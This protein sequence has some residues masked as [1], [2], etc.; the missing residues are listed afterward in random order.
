[1]T[2]AWKAHRLCQAH[3]Q[4]PSQ[5]PRLP[6]APTSLRPAPL[7]P[8]PRWVRGA[9][10]STPQLLPT[11]V[12]PSTSAV[13]QL[14]AGGWLLPD[15]SPRPAGPSLPKEAAAS[16]A[17]RKHFLSRRLTSWSVKQLT[18]KTCVPPKGNSGAQSRA[19]GLSWTLAQCQP[20]LL[21]VRFWAVSS[22]FPSACLI[23]VL[24]LIYKSFSGCHALFF[25]CDTFLRGCHRAGS[26]CSQLI[27]LSSWSF[28]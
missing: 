4:P 9:G 18:S 10:S 26:H 17:C 14:G 24:L 8:A 16:S 3:S 5:P 2:L 11:G 15:P 19:P 25:L 20:V 6:S 27:S 7:S 12:S 21:L 23:F 28:S 13:L 1:M 22:A